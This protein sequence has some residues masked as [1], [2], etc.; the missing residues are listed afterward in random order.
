MHT[1]RLS[2]ESPGLG[3][4]PGGSPARVLRH[5]LQKFRR[6]LLTPMLLTNLQGLLGVFWGF[7]GGLLG[8]LLGSPGRLQG[9]RGL[10]CVERLQSRP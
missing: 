9:S 1:D 6:E 7:S 2:W 10:S 5:P 4:P 8:V 3:G